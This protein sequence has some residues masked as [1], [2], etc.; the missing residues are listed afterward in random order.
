MLPSSGW[1]LARNS[2]RS[3]SAT[4]TRNM[5]AICQ[6]TR[7]E[8][9]RGRRSVR[10]REALHELR[11]TDPG[12]ES[13]RGPHQLA[14]PPARAAE[15]RRAEGRQARGLHRAGGD[16]GRGVPARSSRPRA[17]AGKNYMMMETA[18][19]TREFLFVRE[20]RDSGKLGRI[21]FMRGC[22]QQEMAGW[23]GYWEGLP[24][25]HYA[26]HAVSPCLALVQRRG[27]VRLLLRLGP[28]RRSPDR[29]V[30]LAVRRRERAVQGA[31]PA[32]GVRSHPL[33][34]RNGAAVPRELRRL[35]RQDGVRVAAD[36]R[37]DSR[38]F[39]SARSRSASKCPIT[40]TCCRSRSG[41][42]RPRAST[43][44]STRTCPSS[45]AAGTAAR[46]RTWCTSS[47]PASS[48][49]ARRFRCL[50][51]GELDLRRNLC[52]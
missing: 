50:P 25:M 43:T 24:P 33:A 32:A 27:R 37:R 42:S 9:G 2:F 46:I 23:P 15:H 40:R 49:A 47:C 7:A 35:R 30:R 22:H 11:G 45:R 13:R 5:Y 36:R 12:P 20:L 31:R 17:N 38:S 51:V 21:Q 44:P 8:A 48:K 18:I 19:Y 16:H 28:D 39:T 4:P 10:C 29:E 52:A 41:A 14:D 1:G 6:R 34:V 26:T 3:I